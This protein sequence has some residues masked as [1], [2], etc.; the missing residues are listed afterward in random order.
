MRT[1]LTFVVLCLPLI[2][3]GCHSE[4]GHEWVDLGLPSGLK[5]AT[6]NVGASSPE[7]LGEYYAW[8]EL[9]PKINYDLD[10]YAHLEGSHFSKYSSNVDYKSVLDVSDDVAHQCWGGGWRMPTDEDLT[11]LIENCTWEWTTQ[12]GVNGV[13]VSS[14]KNKNSVFLPAA[15]YRRGH[16][17]EN[18]VAS[19]HEVGS[20]GLY[21]SSSLHVAYVYNAWGMEFDSTTVKVSSFDRCISGLPVRPVLCMNDE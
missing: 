16:L 3:H 5:W 8:G 6:C 13:K 11:E 14:L 10:S 21:W 19:L 15:G 17:Y 9:E 1:Y 4:K 7:D 2:L 18:A 20:M 12:N